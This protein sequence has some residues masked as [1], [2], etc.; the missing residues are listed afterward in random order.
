[1]M[2]V[3]DRSKGKRK[4]KKGKS[5]FISLC[6]QRWVIEKSINIQI[7]SISDIEE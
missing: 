7:Y 2:V 1:M 4:K 3:F 5:T 6:F